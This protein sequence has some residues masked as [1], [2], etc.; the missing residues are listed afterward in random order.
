VPRLLAEG[1]LI[2]LVG[3]GAWVVSGATATP[4]AATLATVGVLVLTIG[5][6]LFY[7]GRDRS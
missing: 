2:L 5:I 4:I 1:A 6:V 7:R 3:L